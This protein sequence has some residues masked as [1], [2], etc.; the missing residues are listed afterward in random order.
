MYII[1]KIKKNKFI[2]FYYIYNKSFN[3]KWGNIIKK[4]KKNK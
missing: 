3:K 4:I 2:F 1:N